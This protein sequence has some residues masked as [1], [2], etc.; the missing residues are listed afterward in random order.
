MNEEIILNTVVAEYVVYVNDDE[1][2]SSSFPVKARIIK[3][4]KPDDDTPYSY[5]ISYNTTS[6]GG[7][8]FYY[9]NVSKATL[10]EITNDLKFHLSLF[11]MGGRKVEINQYY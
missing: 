3:S 10:E 9:K 7:T 4:G 6:G 8:S 5:Q 11:N 1:G 2:N